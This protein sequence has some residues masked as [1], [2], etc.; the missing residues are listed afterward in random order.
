MGKDIVMGVHRNIL[1]GE[2]YE[3]LGRNARTS[4]GTIK[5][6]PGDRKEVAEENVEDETP[7]LPSGDLYPVGII[8]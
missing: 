4:A 2:K 3:D 6:E 1:K 5:L 8:E 7:I